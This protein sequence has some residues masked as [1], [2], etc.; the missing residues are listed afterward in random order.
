[1]EK[2]GSR[3]RKKNEPPIYITIPSVSWIISR[4]NPLE[5]HGQSLVLETVTEAWETHELGQFLKKNLD[6]NTRR[7]R[8]IFLREPE[9]RK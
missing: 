5:I 9:R 1:M 3:N 2:R 6:V 4:K 8:G 7:R